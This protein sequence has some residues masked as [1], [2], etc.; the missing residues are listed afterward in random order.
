[1]NRKQLVKFVFMP[2]PELV[3]LFPAKREVVRTRPRTRRLP[4]SP[5]VMSPMIEDVTSVGG[6]PESVAMGPYEW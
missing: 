4:V 1:M 3:N 5:G 2:G 6:P